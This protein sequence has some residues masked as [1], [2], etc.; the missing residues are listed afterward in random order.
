[1][2]NTLKLLGLI[3]IVALVMLGAVACKDKAEEQDPALNGTWVGGFEFGNSI[4]FNNGSWSMEG[5]KGTYTAKDGKL[6]MTATQLLNPDDGK[7]Y[8]KEEALKKFPDIPGLEEEFATMKGTYVIS[9]DGNTL[10]ITWD[11][12][13]PQTLTKV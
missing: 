1:M 8:T 4:T 13:D 6:S 2:K 9:A 7:W 3:A 11:D 12:G 10:T 5:A